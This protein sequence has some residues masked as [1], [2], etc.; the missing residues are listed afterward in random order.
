[1][2]DLL[3][4]VL[5]QTGI[6]RDD[7]HVRVSFSNRHSAF[8]IRHFIPCFIL[9]SPMGDGQRWPPPLTRRGG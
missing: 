9:F 3:I 6:G 5:P 8:D 2:A 4:P 1:M 7:G